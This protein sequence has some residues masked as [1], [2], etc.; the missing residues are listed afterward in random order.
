MVKSREGH[1]MKVHCFKPDVEKP[2]FTLRYWF[3]K[4][5]DLVQ[6]AKDK[7]DKILAKE[8]I[9]YYGDLIAQERSKIGRS[10]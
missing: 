9:V 6:K 5:A 10:I 2:L 7:L 8:P 4:P 1:G 3:I